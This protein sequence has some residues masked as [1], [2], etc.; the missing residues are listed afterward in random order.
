[1]HSVT[2]LNV[3]RQRALPNVDFRNPAEVLASL[4]TR[5]QMDG[6]NG[7]YFTMWYGVYDKRDRTLS[8]GS[9]GHHPAYLI[10]PDRRESQPL[11]SPALMVGAL[12]ISEYEVHRTTVPAGSALYL[13]SDGVFDIQ[14]KDQEQWSQSDFLPL[15]LEPPLPGTPEPERL[16]QAVRQAARPGPF[17]DDFSLMVVTFV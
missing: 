16:Y 17:D 3:L 4:N 14:T 11:G 8:Y 13:F 5:F 7:M 1:M 6:H 10:P 9:G 2:V 12:P 15:L